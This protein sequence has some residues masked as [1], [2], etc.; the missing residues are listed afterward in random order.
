VIAGEEGA[1][2]TTEVIDRVTADSGPLLGPLMDTYIRL[3]PGM[4]TRVTGTPETYR[5][6][7]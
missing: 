4:Q 3:A 6:I 2:M 7:R 5:C 1:K